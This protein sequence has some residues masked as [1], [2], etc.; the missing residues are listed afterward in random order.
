MWNVRINA[1][2]IY[3]WIGSSAFTQCFYTL[4]NEFATLYPGAPTGAA[5]EMKGA[6]NERIF[7]SG[8]GQ[9]KQNLLLLLIIYNMYPLSSQQWVTNFSA[10][11]Y[12]LSPSL[13]LHICKCKDRN[14]PYS[15]NS[16]M[17]CFHILFFA[18]LT[19][20]S[21]KGVSLKGTFSL[22]PFLFLQNSQLSF[23]RRVTNN[24]IKT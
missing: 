23:R 15:W 2:Y 11:Q 21:P 13:N 19:K 12:I 7:N 24:Q 4:L 16:S 20:K 3:R 22:T 5:P 9:G 1:P 8:T 6:E 14:F 17:L 18:T 10:K